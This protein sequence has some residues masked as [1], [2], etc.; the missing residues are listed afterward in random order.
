MHF[1]FLTC[2][3]T[4]NLFLLRLL[5]IFYRIYIFTFK[6]LFAISYFKNEKMKCQNLM[7]VL[8]SHKFVEFLQ[9]FY[10]L[11]LSDE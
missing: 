8:F 3:H 11:A 4:T 9:K 6:Q 1:E 2:P 7:D 10:Q 5:L